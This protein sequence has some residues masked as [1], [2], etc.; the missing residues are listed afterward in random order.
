VEQLK[1]TIAEL[2]QAGQRMG[3]RYAFE[4]LPAYHPVGSDVAELAAILKETGAPN[5][6]MCFDTGHANMVCDPAD[7]LSTT[8]GQVIYVHLNDNDGRE[9][10]HLMPTY[11]TMDMQ[12]IARSLHKIDYHGTLMLEVFCSVQRLKQ[13]I[14]EGCAER[15]NRIVDAANG[16]PGD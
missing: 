3:V 14:D 6:G 16:S 2:G 12:A 8:G 11:G 1:K 5:T 15:L 10:G 13:F 4:N 7:S 9:D